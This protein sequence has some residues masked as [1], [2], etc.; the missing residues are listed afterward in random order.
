M[1]RKPW[2][3]LLSLSAAVVPF[4][5]PVT[6]HVVSRFWQPA[7]TA[8]I[9][10][11]E[12]PRGTLLAALRARNQSDSTIAIGM[13]IA[14]RSHGVTVGQLR[15]EWQ[16]VAECEVGGNWSMT[17]PVYSGIGFLNATWSSYGGR[18]FAP[19]AGQATRDEQIVVAMRV[20]G[21]WVPDQHGCSPSGW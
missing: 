10:A 14:A 20:T 16:N 2:A 3:V 17:G 4:S 18:Q 9:R 13:L 5:A 15:Q 6:S 1:R 8:P 19:L 7:P 21:G 11:P 12:P